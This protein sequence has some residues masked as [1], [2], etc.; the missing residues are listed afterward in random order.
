MAQRSDPQL[1]EMRRAW[2][3]IVRKRLRSSDDEDE[4]GT[5]EVVTGYYCQF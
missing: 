4:K 1:E 2:P 5:P 3:A